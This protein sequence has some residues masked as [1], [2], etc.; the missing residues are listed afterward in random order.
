[1]KKARIYQAF[2]PA[3]ALM[4]ASPAAAQN[5]DSAASA[6]TIARDTLLMA[7][8]HACY[9]IAVA[10]DP[11]TYGN[12]LGQVYLADTGKIQCAI[13]KAYLSRAAK[14]PVTEQWETSD[15]AGNQTVAKLGH[16]KAGE[17]FIQVVEIYAAGY[18]NRMEGTMADATAT[19]RDKDR[20][21][22]FYHRVEDWFKV[23]Q[24]DLAPLPASPSNA[25]KPQPRP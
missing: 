8:H 22:G 14:K 15:K 11:V 5:K 1:M 23:A 10:K 25:A 6:E 9:G 20:T 18:N 17:I 21:V 16:N 2:G 24:Q 4:V 13:S 7:D 3:I 19:N 12:D